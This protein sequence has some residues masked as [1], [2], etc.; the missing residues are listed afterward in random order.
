[1]LARL[2]HLS[3]HSVSFLE[4]FFE[5]CTVDEKIDAPYICIN[6]KRNK[7]SFLRSG[8][9]LTGVDIILN[10][11][12]SPMMKDWELFRGLNEEWFTSHGGCSIYVFYLPDSKPL[13]TEYKPDVRYIIDR[14]VYRDETIDGFDGMESLHMI[15][16]FGIAFKKRLNKRIGADY[17]EIATGF[18]NGTLTEEEVVRM[19]SDCGQ[20]NLFAVAEPEG[21]ILRKGKKHIYQCL[22]SPSDDRHKEVTDSARSQ[23]EFL[24]LDFL[25]FWDSIGDI[26]AHT[27]CGDYVKTVCS[28]FND[29]CQWQTQNGEP[30][31]NNIEASGLEPPYIGRK[32]QTDFR[33]IPNPKTVELCRND[34][35][36]E[37]V[38]K[39][40]L[41]NLQNEKR[42][43]DCVLMN[44]SHTEKWNTIVKTLQ[45][46]G[47]SAQKS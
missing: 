28:L 19:I 14:I 1:M 35:L 37:N 11:D 7:F 47:L 18:R 10:S 39:V 44:S 42:F 24:L 12:Y 43:D 23:Y 36:M 20:D 9:Q 46:A 13:G 34:I 33:H 22:L 3:S 2:K 41:V 17:T 38:L 4:R 32:P 25:K 6:I 5:N 15:E 31:R 8:R 21:Y 27:D 45:N 29:Y 16:K 30:L 40:L 26:Y